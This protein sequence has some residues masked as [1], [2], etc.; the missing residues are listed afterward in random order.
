VSPVLYPPQAEW[1]ETA[2]TG[3]Y[4]MGT[5]SRIR[6]RRYHALLMHAQSPSSGRRV[7][8]PGFDAW[9]ECCGQRIP[10][11][12]QCYSRGA[13]SP[14]DAL[15]ASSFE[16]RPWPT[17]TFAAAGGSWCEEFFISPKTAEAVLRWK[18]AALPVN[19]RFCLRPFLACR[20][21]HALQRRDERFR[22]EPQRQGACFVWRP[23]AAEPGLAIFTSGDYRHEPYWYDHFEYDEE[24]ARGFDYVEDLAS[25][26]VFSW[27]LGGARPGP[28]LI[29]RSVEADAAVDELGCGAAD[30]AA[31]LAESERERRAEM[32]PLEFSASQY[33]VRRG[34]G[35]SII[36]GY[37][38][39]TDW[40][41]DTFV[42]IR[43]LYISRGKLAEARAVVETWASAVVDGLAPNRFDDDAGPDYAAADT[44]LWFIIAAAE[45]TAAMRTAKRGDRVFEQLCRRTTDSILAH[46]IR[47]TKY[48]IRADNDGLLCAGEPG[49]ALTWMDACVEGK[50]VTPRIG[51]PVELECLWLNALNTARRRSAETERVVNTASRS[52]IERFWNAERGYLADVVD[53]NH[54][55]GTEDA[56]L[57]PNQIFAV[58]GLPRAT[59]PKRIGRRVLDAVARDLYTP[60]GLRTLS[61]SD[62]AYRAEYAG[63][64]AARDAAYHQGTVWPWLLGAFG[65]AWLRVHNDPVGRAWVIRNCADPLRASLEVGGLGHLF[66]ITDAETPATP[67][68]CPF[69]AWSLGEF[70]R[71]E[72]LCVGP[73]TMKRKLHV[74]L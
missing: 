72:G 57:R 10:L 6:T 32:S 1:L 55:R 44:S 28:A 34:E 43:G 60:L 12:Q 16:Y 56:S 51:K 49:R 66:E 67:K 38:W 54:V 19:A 41:R 47:G 27:A 21:Y 18:G 9:I 23:Y 13:F 17:W 64:P 39:F 25:P 71:L 73:E 11:S 30:Y 26:G 48:G 3:A 31:R 40:G 24:R 58:G 42:A 14:G 35:A 7:L 53:V 4:A 22:L 63:G 50:P 15:K 65:E 61:R 36:A 74:L 2:G 37:P 8:M 45:L 62:P 33:L 52:F 68:G 46:F 69:Q 70:L 59:V 20:D 5:V 29:L